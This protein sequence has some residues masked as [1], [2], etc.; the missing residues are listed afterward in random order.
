MR[1]QSKQDEATCLGQPG[2]KQQSCWIPESKL[3]TSVLCLILNSG[4]F[5][6]S[7]LY[8]ESSNGKCPMASP[9]H[10][11]WD[12]RTCL[13]L[14]HQQMALISKRRTPAGSP[15]NRAIFSLWSM[16]K[17]PVVH[18]FPL[19]TSEVSCHLQLAVKDAIKNHVLQ[20]LLTQFTVRT[21][22]KWF[23]VLSFLP[24][25]LMTYRKRVC[26]FQLPQKNK[27]FGCPGVTTTFPYIWH[28]SME[29][30]CL[31]TVIDTCVFIPV[32]LFFLISLWGALWGEK[33]GYPPSI[34]FLWLIPATY[35]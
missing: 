6:S 15:G 22:Q 14:H 2:N 20:P 17:W 5:G 11:L 18:S 33:P 12:S 34:K 23:L 27:I 4:Y 25:E 28:R 26:F 9:S 30:S 21:C 16:F 10:D 3:L 13:Y 8:V 7:R 29:V 24:M 32:K 19:G 35:L 1:K 31:N